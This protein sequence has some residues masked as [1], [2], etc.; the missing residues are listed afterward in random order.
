MT[1]VRYLRG[2][3]V[4]LRRQSDHSPGQA[5][6]VL[7]SDVRE[8][9]GDMVELIQT[10]KSKNRIL[11]IITSSLLKKR[12]GELEVAINMAINRLQVCNGIE[13]PWHPCLA[14]VFFVDLSMFVPDI[15]NLPRTVEASQLPLEKR[16]SDLAVCY[17][18]RVS[19]NVK[20]VAVVSRELATY[21]EVMTST[22]WWCRMSNYYSLRSTCAEAVSYTPW[23]LGWSRLRSQSRNVWTNTSSATSRFRPLREMEWFSMGLTD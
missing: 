1:A 12:Q 2:C 19:D 4:L 10:Y 6:H 14:E 22:A 23:G 20:L 21:T 5:E 11:Q 13:R 15:D 9:I 18:V 8:A 7:L 16:W 17:R 3:L